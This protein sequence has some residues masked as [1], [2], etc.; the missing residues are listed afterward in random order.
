MKG[1]LDLICRPEL[2][3]GHFKGA[4]Q[5]TLAAQTSANYTDERMRIKAER[6]IGLAIKEVLSNF[7]VTFDH[8]ISQHNKQ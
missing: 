4:I 1:P 6:H 3:S 7:S 5:P 2:T 8:N